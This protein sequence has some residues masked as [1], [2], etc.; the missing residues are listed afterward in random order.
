MS[1]KIIAKHYF[2]HI[3]NIQNANF[4]YEEKETEYLYILVLTSKKSDFAN[5]ENIPLERYSDKLEAWEAYQNESIY[6]VLEDFKNKSTISLSIYFIDKN[7]IAKE[8][9]DG[10]I[11]PL[12]KNFVL[13]ADAFSLNFEENQTFAKLFDS[14]DKNK[15]YGCLVPLC[16]TFSENQRS[17]AKKQ[18]KQTFKRLARAWGSEFYKSYTHTE[19]DIPNK[20]H[21]FRRLANIAY[22]KG[23]KEKETMKK[24]EAKSKKFTQENLKNM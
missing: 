7:I 21:F 4:F 2:E 20:T 22:L 12:T 15:T 5:M 6:R 18:I 9:L 16:N 24:F 3:A 14:K 13:I 8:D 17:F 23:I 11:E 10:E 1:E 19:L